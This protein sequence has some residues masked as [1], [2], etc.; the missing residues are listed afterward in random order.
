MAVGALEVSRLAGLLG[1]SVF[2]LVAVVPTV[3]DSVAVPGRGDAL[4]VFALELIFLTSVVT[5]GK[6]LQLDSCWKRPTLQTESSA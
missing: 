5:C 6:T 4:L 1:A 2:V 3:V